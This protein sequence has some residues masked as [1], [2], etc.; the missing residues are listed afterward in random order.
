[1]KAIRTF[2]VGILAFAAFGFA[3]ASAAD[4]PENLPTVEPGKLVMSINATIPPRQFIDSSGNLQGLHP[5]LGNEIARRLCLEPDFRNVGFEVQIPG[6]ANQR[7]DMINTG[8][9]YTEERSKIIRLVPYTVNAL[10]IVVERGNPLGVTGY[11]ELAGHPVGTEIAGFADR[12][13]RE[14]NDEQVARGLQPMQIQAFNTFAEAFAALGAGQV[15]GVFAPDS[16]GAYYAERGQFDVGAAGLNPGLPSAFGFDPGAAEL[17]E[18][19]ARVLSE[20]RAD[21]TY[22]AMMEAYGAT[23]IDLWEK[24]SG[25]FE[26]FYAPAS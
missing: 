11:E 3:S 2:G 12:L 1:M 5:D 8:M 20:M 17:A 24:W 23:Q 26:V 6:L 4:C 9:Y 21:G 14:I 25:D 15:R 18:A 13:I 16:T 22:Q 19:V 10:A 7:W